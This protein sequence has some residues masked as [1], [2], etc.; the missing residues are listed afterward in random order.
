MAE[1]LRH[2][3]RVA[4][5]FFQGV[6]LRL[7]SNALPYQ[8]VAAA[9]VG[10]SHQLVDG[11]IQHNVGEQEH[12]SALHGAKLASVQ[13][14]GDLRGVAVHLNGH[15]GGGVLEVAFAA[16]IDERF[17]TPAGFVEIERLLFL[18]AV[19]GHKTLVV[20]PLNAALVADV[21][22]KV[23]HIPQ[24]RCPDIGALLQGAVGFFVDD[25][26]VFFGVVLNFGGGAVPAQH[27]FCAVFADGHRDIGN[28][29]V[30]FVTE[31]AM[32]LDR[33]LIPALVLVVG[34]HIGHAE[35]PAGCRSHADIGNAGQ[36]AGVK[37]LTQLVKAMDNVEH[38]LALAADA[39]FIGN[40]PEADGGVVVVLQNQLPH[41]TEQVFV[42]GRVG[43]VQAN[44]GNLRPYNHSLAVAKLVEKRVV[45]VVRQTDRVGTDF[46]NH[47]H[48]FQ[49]FLLGDAP[50]HI[51]TVL[52]TADAVQRIRPPVE[53]KSLVGG[54]GIAAEAEGISQHINGGAILVQGGGS[55]V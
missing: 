17:L 16:D 20:A 4:L 47:R 11:A 13:Q 2:I 19:K 39:D 49:M 18:F 7:G 3:F 26:L 46:T 55:R 15:G 52:V 48:I 54:D 14:Q 44:K 33:A 1:P 53:E 42:G 6:F 36:T 25:G 5:G 9:G 38:S 45:L 41:L 28:L 43:N 40:A 29:P 12:R 24:P 32:I 34:G 21:H 31:R 8:A 27:S 30:A 50:A 37:L 51:L 10:H 23:K 22:G 35:Q